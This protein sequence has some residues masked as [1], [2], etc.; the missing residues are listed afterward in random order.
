MNPIVALPL[1][2]LGVFCWLSVGAVAGWLAN[3][4]LEA[5]RL[6]SDVVLGM[7]GAVPCGYL[8]GLVSTDPIAFLG[9]ILFAFAGACLLVALFRLVFPRRWRPSRRAN[10]GR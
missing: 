8:F 3:A 9:S 2:A 1:D 4:V 7:V 10:S 5:R 6:A